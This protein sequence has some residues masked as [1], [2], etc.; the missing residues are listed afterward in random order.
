MAK[1]THLYDCDLRDDAMVICL[2]CGHSTP[3]ATLVRGAALSR[4]PE[5][6]ESVRTEIL[7]RGGVVFWPPDPPA[8]S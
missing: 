4:P 2:R 1:H 5:V 3:T 8:E 6:S 7:A